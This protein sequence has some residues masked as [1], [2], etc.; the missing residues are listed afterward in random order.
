MQGGCELGLEKQMFSFR[1]Q[2]EAEKLAK[3]SHP[4][5]AMKSPEILSCPQ[6]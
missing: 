4:Y 3:S 6:E 1:R 5:Q 2:R